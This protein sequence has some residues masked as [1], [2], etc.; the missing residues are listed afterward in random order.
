[1]RK[2]VRRKRAGKNEIDTEML[3]CFMALSPRA[4]LRHLERLNAFLRQATPARSKTV[5]LRLRKQGW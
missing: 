4:K 3:R 5:W 1:M 2:A